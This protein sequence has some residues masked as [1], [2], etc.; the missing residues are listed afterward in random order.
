MSCP[1][2]LASARRSAIVAGFG[3]A[4][5]GWVGRVALLVLE[6]LP[7][8]QPAATSEAAMRSPAGSVVSIR[9][10]VYNL[11]SGAES[12]QA[13][14]GLRPATPSATRRTREQRPRRPRRLR[15]R[16]MLS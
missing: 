8:P 2:L 1:V 7:P 12:T 13:R 6:E 4:R 5:T 3:F 14:E 10:V 15:Q 16:L 9:M 11:R